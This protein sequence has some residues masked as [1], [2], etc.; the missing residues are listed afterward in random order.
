MPRKSPYDDTDHYTN[1][2]NHIG[3][4]FQRAIFPLFTK[5]VEQ[6]YS[7][8]QLSHLVMNE[9]FECEL[10][11]MLDMNKALRKEKLPEAPT[12]APSVPPT[13]L[14]LPVPKRALKGKR[15]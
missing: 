6:G 12:S 11:A 10:L 9:V 15:P 5:Y 7:I 8:R 2:T 4:E 1:Q 13:K 3:G 14:P